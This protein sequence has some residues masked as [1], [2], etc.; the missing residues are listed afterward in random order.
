MTAVLKQ[1]MARQGTA[2]KELREYCKKNK[3]TVSKHK[4]YEA[5]ETAA[6]KKNLGLPQGI[7]NNISIRS[8]SQLEQHMLDDPDGE[9]TVFKLG[10]AHGKKTHFAIAQ[11]DTKSDHKWF[12]NDKDARIH[13]NSNRFTGDEIPLSKGLFSKCLPGNE[14]GILSRVIEYMWKSPEWLAATGVRYK[15]IE[16]KFKPTHLENKLLTWKSGGD[17]EVDAVVVSQAGDEVLIV[18]GKGRGKE[19][20]K[21]QIAFSYKAVRTTL[22]NNNRDP[23]PTITPI[24][25]VADET[26]AYICWCDWKHDSAITNMKIDKVYRAKL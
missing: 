5:F 26:Y 12:F 3:M 13:F 14:S 18:E 1:F 9:W 6:K 22:T 24:I 2:F 16:F 8:R 7:S 17:I 19:V 15:P 20:F 10:A 23:L 21:G 11:T 25:V 4:E